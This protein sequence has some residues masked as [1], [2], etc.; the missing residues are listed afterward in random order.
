M[1]N[2]DRNDFNL[3]ADDRVAVAEACSK[4]SGQDLRLSEAVVASKASAAK[5]SPSMIVGT[6]TSTGEAQVVSVPIAVSRPDTVACS[7]SGSQRG[8]NQWDFKEHAAASEFSSSTVPRESELG[9]SMSSSSEI[10][11]M[12]LTGSSQ[13]SSIVPSYAKLPTASESA[14][15]TVPTNFQIGGSSSSSSA[16]PGM[17]LTGSSL[18]STIVPNYAKLPTE[19]CCVHLCPFRCYICRQGIPHIEHTCL[20]CENW[21]LSAK[22]EAVARLSRFERVSRVRESWSERD[23]GNDWGWWTWKRDSWHR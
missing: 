3:V 8:W 18:P 1:K 17:C 19:P 22:S 7:Q 9:G 12:C 16:I 20:Q 13:P 4:N 10:P 15:S 2:S 21:V 5:S 23:W 14:S 11:G 6:L